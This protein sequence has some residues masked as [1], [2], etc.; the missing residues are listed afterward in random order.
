MSQSSTLD[1]FRLTF[2]GSH[3]APAELLNCPRGDLARG[4]RTDNSCAG[5]RGDF[6]T[7]LRTSSA[8]PSIGDFATGARIASSL[9]VIGDFGTGMRALPAADRRP[10]IISGTIS[11]APHGHSLAQMPQPSQ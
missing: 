8:S 6:A 1:N 5:I 10:Q 7:G 3:P 2:S 9:A 4:Q 11:I